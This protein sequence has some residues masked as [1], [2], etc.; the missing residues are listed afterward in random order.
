MRT[1]FAL[2]VDALGPLLFAATSGYVL[3]SF[4]SGA[5]LARMGLG[6]LL[7]LSCLATAAS[8]AGYALAPGWAVVV[9]CGAVAG[10][11]AGAIDAGI[12]TYAAERHGV[13]TLNLLHACYG[14]GAS[15]GP[16]IMTA[17]LAAGAPWQRGYAIVA[18]LQLALAAAF[19]ATRARWEAPRV[20]D[21]APPVAPAPLADTL[22]RPAA[23]LG[24]AAFLLYTGLEASFGVWSY[25][26][27]T[28][29]RAMAATTA[30]LWVSVFW[31]GLAAGRLL[32]G[33]A[34][35]RAAVERLLF[36][37]TLAVAL[38]AG[39]IWLRLGSAPSLAGVAL[40]GIACGPIF[41][42]LVATTRAR[43]G[44]PHAANAIGFQVAGAAIGQSLLPAA[45]G[46][47]VR[48]RGIEI[49]PLALF[50]AALGLVGIYAVLWSGGRRTPSPRERRGIEAASWM[51]RPAWGAAGAS[52]A[53][54]A[55]T[56]E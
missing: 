49:V 20:T 19:C 14:V 9:A 7:A 25:S 8:L 26:V 50:A 38:G 22:R 3:S 23:W 48:S 15:A 29:G 27:F 18:A 56:K 24:V 4:G 1:G 39:L 40:A 51:E 35:A 21:A 45:L 44:A 31:G 17:V 53:V 55:R 30:G 6:S 10:L 13:R 52:N 54:D 46:A 37:C 41:P 34:G 36:A 43:L 33:L 11:G 12:N 42:S 32:F 2:R 5:V 28:E 16:T 47:L